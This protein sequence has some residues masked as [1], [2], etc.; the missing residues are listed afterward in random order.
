MLNNSFQF[1]YVILFE[2]NHQLQRSVGTVYV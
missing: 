2:Q 1:I